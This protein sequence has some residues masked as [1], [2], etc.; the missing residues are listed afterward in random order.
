[1][2]KKHWKAGAEYKYGHLQNAGTK[3]LNV[4]I[5]DGKY[6]TSFW[7]IISHIIDK[8]EMLH[9]SGKV[10]ILRNCISSR[11]LA[12]QNKKIKQII[13]EEPEQSDVNEEILE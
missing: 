9:I 2:S 13:S 8:I 12:S 7:K 10:E 5:V 11:F 1:M 4:N 3:K 6:P